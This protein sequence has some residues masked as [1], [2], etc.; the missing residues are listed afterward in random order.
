[1]HINRIKVHIKQTATEGAR[2]GTKVGVV[3]L[4]QCG[5]GED[6]VT[7]YARRLRVSVLPCQQ[8]YEAGSQKIPD[9]SVL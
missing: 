9:A 5:G 4:W 6:A 1:M 7:L 8:K 2:G 3:C